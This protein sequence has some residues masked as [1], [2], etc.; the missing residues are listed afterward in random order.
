[1]HRATCNIRRASCHRPFGRPSRG[2]LATACLGRPCIAVRAT[3]RPTRRRW[4]RCTRAWPSS[5]ASALRAP[6]KTRAVTWHATDGTPGVQRTM[7]R[8][9]IAR[10]GR[11]TRCATATAPRERARAC[12]RLR[13]KGVWAAGRAQPLSCLRCEHADRQLHALANQYAASSAGPLHPCGR[14]CGT[15][16]GVGAWDAEAYLGDAMQQAPSVPTPACNDCPACV[17]RS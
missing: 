3:L 15:M 8:F 11:D 7:S 16:H 13:A 10:T 12:G 9:Q 6:A 5:S 17:L 1:M 14:A 4:T 2:P